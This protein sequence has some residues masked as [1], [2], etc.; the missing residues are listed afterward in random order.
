[1]NISID[2]VFKAYAVWL[3]ALSVA[4]FFIYGWDKWQSKRE[5]WRTPEK[6]LHTLALLG[7]FP[8]AIAG[9]STFRHKTQ[10]KSFG[11]VIFLSAILHSGV[12]FVILK[13]L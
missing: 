7:G 1:M 3:L 11:V 6:R 2:P 12:L 10:K 8:G 4:T 5:G 13:Y 9:R